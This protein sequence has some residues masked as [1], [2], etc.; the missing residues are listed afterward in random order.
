M[1]KQFLPHLEKQ[2]SSAIV[3]ITSGLAFVPFP[4]SRVYSVTKAGLHA[5][6]QALRVHPL[7]ERQPPR[8]SHSRLQ[9]DF[10]KAS[11][12]GRLRRDQLS[13]PT[14]TDG[15]LLKKIGI[16]ALGLVIAALGAWSFWPRSALPQDAKADLVVVHKSA[17]RL[18]LYRRNVLLESY[19]V[20]LGRHPNGPKQ[21]Q[22]D[23]KTPEGEYS[24]DY[25]KADSSF[26]RALHIS[27]P[28][29]ADIAFA[30]SH[31]ID[32]GGLVMIHGMRNGLGW[33]GRLHRLVDWTD[34][35]VA[36]TDEEMDELW[37]AVPDGTKILLKP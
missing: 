27:Y 28:G 34:G 25:R 14:M 16:V 37:R 36:V 24:L 35:C 30:R 4:I 33:I 32:P 11:G 20:S 19:T 9:V 22:G 23:G 7:R 31:G 29:P 18:E 6:T 21:Q 12:A 5:F 3:N 15:H 8:S 17:H 10:P 1:V 2:H 13:N 26:H